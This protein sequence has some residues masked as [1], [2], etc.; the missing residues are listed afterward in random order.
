MNKARYTLGI[1]IGSTASKCIIMKD[2]T[3]IIAKA[4]IAVGAGTTG[5]ARA[6]DEALKQAGLT[7]G[8][9][10]Y[11]VATGYG[12]N[13]FAGA[14][15]QMSELSCHAKGAAFMFPGVR[16]IIDIGGQDA[17]VLSVSPAGKLINFLMN[18]KC[19]AGTGRFMEVMS[20]VL[21]EDIS[22]FAEMSGKSAQRI[23][24]SST[25]TVFAETEVISY[26]AKAVPVEDIIAGIHRSVAS[27]V[28]NLAKRANVTSPVVITG[29]V[30]KNAGIVKAL[31]AEINAII[32]CNEYCQLNGAIGAALYAY[33]IL[34]EE[35]NED[36]QED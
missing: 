4:I 30:A 13:T 29:G 22:S 12:R 27:R 24:I 3:E 36:G 28:G 26:L 33:D 32:H 9:I 6:L 19:A 15:E 14:D 21:D 16:T 18:D 7:K 23:D 2:R 10:A 17:K 20:R 25:C 35:E 31:G 34:L 11:T 5:P 1:D 8:D